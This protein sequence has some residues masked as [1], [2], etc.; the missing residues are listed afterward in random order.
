[1]KHASADR[2]GIFVRFA[3][4]GES[5]RIA[6]PNKFRFRSKKRV[7]VQIENDLLGRALDQRV[8]LRKRLLVAPRDMQCKFS[9]RRFRFDVLVRKTQQTGKTNSDGD[10]E[11]RK[12]FHSSHHECDGHK[13]P[14]QTQ[15][16]VTL[17]A[18]LAAPISLALRTARAVYFNSPFLGEVSIAGVRK[19]KPTFCGDLSPLPCR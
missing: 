19:K 7:F 8:A 18:S 10:E 1:M 6:R 11:D 17:T 2:L 16:T 4:I 12:P 13:P 14:R 9:I 5:L 3:H 15:L